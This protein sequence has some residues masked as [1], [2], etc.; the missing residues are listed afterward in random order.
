MLF[1]KFINTFLSNSRVKEEIIMEMR[2]Y[3]E[4]NNN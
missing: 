2:K 4:P 1:Y 3:A